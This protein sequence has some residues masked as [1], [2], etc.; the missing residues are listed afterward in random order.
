MDPEV[1]VPFDLCG[2]FGDTNDGDTRS[3]VAVV[4]AVVMGRTIGLVDAV[5][6][7]VVG[8]GVVVVVG[9]VVVVSTV[10][11]IANR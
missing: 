8:V 2:S 7:V 6:V 9:F 11:A 5:L 1:G 10:A 3:V 4:D